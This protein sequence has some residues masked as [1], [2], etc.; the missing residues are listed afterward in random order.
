[1]GTALA[2][3]KS[4]SQELH[5]ALTLSSSYHLLL[6][7]LRRL[8]KQFA[9]RSGEPRVHE[10]SGYRRFAGRQL[11]LHSGG[12]RPFRRSGDVLAAHGS[13]RRDANRQHDQ[14][15]TDFGRI[16][17][18]QRL[19]GASHHFFRGHGNPIVD[20]HAHRHGHDQ[21]GQYRKSCSAFSIPKARSTGSWMVTSWIVTNDA[22]AAAIHQRGPPVR[23]QAD[24]PSRRMIPCSL[25]RLTCFLFFMMRSSSVQS[26]THKIL[27]TNVSRETFLREGA[28]LLCSYRGA[29]GR[30]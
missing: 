25:R 4:C 13:S 29:P 1:M 11:R 14:L 20:R 9:Y 21:L 30:K 16:A 26:Y 19:H 3:V 6:S 5:C 8:R 24:A 18:L 27:C 2:R 17:R 10:H 15:G 12:N 22:L 7:L 23:C 28:G